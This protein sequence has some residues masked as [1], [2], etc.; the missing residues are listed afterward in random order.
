MFKKKSSLHLSLQSSLLS[1][2][3]RTLWR[4][5]RRRLKPI[6]H[7]CMRTC[8]T[9]SVRWRIRYLSASTSAELGC[10]SLPVFLSIHQHSTSF[11]SPF[12]LWSNFCHKEPPPFCVCVVVGCVF[13]SVPDV[14]FTFHTPLYCLILQC[15][16]VC[17]WFFCFLLFCFEMTLSIPFWCNYHSMTNVLCTDDLRDMTN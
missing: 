13:V 10:L 14:F 2:S 5:V 8:R 9:L 17:V 6:T 15:C 16:C 7:S 12:L 4:K 1:L 3:L 11:F